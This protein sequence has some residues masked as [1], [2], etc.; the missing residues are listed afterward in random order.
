MFLTALLV[1]NLGLALHL[2]WGENGVLDY[3]EHKAIRNQLLQRLQ[4]LREE[5][6]DLSH[7]IRLLKT[8]KDYQELIVRQELHYLGQDEILY[9]LNPRMSPG[10]K[11]K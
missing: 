1:L 5:N 10:G 8:N 11:A 9:I 6:L 2:I 3:R 7:R 4:R